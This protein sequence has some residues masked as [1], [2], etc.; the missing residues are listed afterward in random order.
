[1]SFRKSF[2]VLI[3]WIGIKANYGQTFS[4]QNIL[5]AHNNIQQ[6]LNK[7]YPGDCV[8]IPPGTYFEN[9][10]TVRSGTRKAFIQIIGLPGAKIMGK[11]VP[12][13]RVIE[14]KHSY[15]VVKSLEINGHFS[16]ENKLKAYKDKLIYIEGKPHN[17][18]HDI[19][20]INNL[21]RNAWGE[22]L[23][24]KYA[25]N[26]QIFNNF[27]S[28]CGL[29]DSRFKRGKKNGEGIYV[30]TAPEQAVIP[31]RSEKIIIRGNVILRV[32]ECVDVK[33]KTSRVIIEEN[34]CG[35]TWDPKSGGVSIR[36][37][38]NIARNNLFFSLSGAG[39]RLGG[40]TEKDGIKN[41][42]YG[43]IFLEKIPFPLKIM[44]APQA[45]ICGNM[46][47]EPRVYLSSKIRE[48]YEKYWKK[49]FEPCN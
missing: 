30:G 42:I 43:N 36:G 6:A 29:R 38:K 34:Y 3:F 28:D 35:Y 23:R 46:V 10:T 13:K 17:Y 47:L 8:I 15:I 19:K 20:I 11:P 25:K 33:E 18:V 48:I 22:C 4:C 12:G 1:M 5:I 27:I 16:P 39:I 45:K 24:I 32:S 31:D 40:D 49:F 26:I 2:L 9:I 44:R 7:A 41:E 37:N 14:I 21:L